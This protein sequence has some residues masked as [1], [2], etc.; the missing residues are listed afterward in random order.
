VEKESDGEPTG[1]AG[2]HILIDH[3]AWKNRVEKA[4]KKVEKV[5]I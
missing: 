4:E 1:L 5:K 3:R 2:V